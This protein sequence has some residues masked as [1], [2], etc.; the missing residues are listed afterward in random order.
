MLKPSSW[1]FLRCK[2]A[3]FSALEETFNE[4]K[5]YRYFMTLLLGNNWPSPHVLGGW[6]SFF[7]NAVRFPPSNYLIQWKF[8]LIA[9][10]NCDHIAIFSSWERMMRGKVSDHKGLLCFFLIDPILIRPA[11]RSQHP[12]ACVCCGLSEIT[13]S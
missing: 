2:N 11:E 6:S 12:P 13:S 9:W 8:W 5:D 10:K 7:T 1:I 4:V 3:L